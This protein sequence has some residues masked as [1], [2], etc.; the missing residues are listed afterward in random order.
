RLDNTEGAKSPFWSPD[1]K[2]VG[3]FA[4]G[5]LKTIDVESGT[6]RT[7]ADAPLS[8]GG[9]WSERG[10]IVFGR[11]IAQPLYRINAAGGEAI[12]VTQIPRERTSWTS[13]SPHFLPDGEHFLYTVA[14]TT[15]GEGS[16]SG[17]YAGSLSSPSGTLVSP[18]I[19]GNVQF[20]AGHLL[21][22]RE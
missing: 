2:Q 9:S 14:W 15:P 19:Q 11:G 18:D 3:F 12:A 17:L 8:T 21:F 20:A 1:G 16:G 13:W 7:L 4:G 5:K 22:V 10:V 6:Q